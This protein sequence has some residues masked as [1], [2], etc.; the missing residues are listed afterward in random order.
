MRFYN[1]SVIAKIEPFCLM[2]LRFTSIIFF[3]A[4]IPNL[5]IYSLKDA[6]A[7]PY[8]GIPIYVLN[9]PGLFLLFSEFLI[10]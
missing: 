4:K 7:Q 1:S 5:S 3:L 8:Y 10:I 9:P 6:D 2:F